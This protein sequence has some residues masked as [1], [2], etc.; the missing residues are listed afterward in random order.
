V[1]AIVY[2]D[3]LSYK[4]FNLAMLKRLLLLVFITLFVFISR[5]TFSQEETSRVLGFKK[6]FLI[7]SNGDTI[8]GAVSNPFNDGISGSVFFRSKKGR[9][10]KFSPF[11]AA[12]FGIYSTGKVY[13]A[14]EIPVKAGSEF[15]FTRIILDGDY[16]LLY[17]EFLGTHHFLIKTPYGKITDLMR[18]EKPDSGKPVKKISDS[19]YYQNLKRAFADNPQILDRHD[20]VEQERRSLERL[21]T[22]YYRKNGI[23]YVNYKAFGKKIYSEI[24]LGS[25]FSRLVPFPEVKS[26]HNV[27]SPSPF[28]GITVR[29]SNINTGLGVF[30]QSVFGY[31]SYHFYYSGKNAS[32]TEFNESFIKSY[33]ST[34]RA[35]FFAESGSKRKIRPFIETGPMASVLISAKYE[36]YYDIL[37]E[38][39][40]T[41][42]S[43]HNHDKLFPDA[44]YGAFVRAGM[45]VK[46]KNM[47]P[48]RIS[49]G[50]DY[51]LS[52]KKAGINSVDLEL[53]YRLK[54]RR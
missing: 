1:V 48:L 53:S 9:P 30:L 16:D 25:G 22:N 28:A 49:I 18:Q 37:R 54:F 8:R 43:T 41:V 5:Q 29:A 31:N 32:G 7:K 20:Q 52:S 2:T 35:G 15:L 45:T 12:G 46:L 23:K 17:Y 39:S 38:S 42:F 44:Y 27:Y 50:Y 4:P 34:S 6:G 51:L 3:I 26:L 13:A 19:L 36:N 11:E 33:V 14:N 40:G 10:A 47:N 21:L 24:L